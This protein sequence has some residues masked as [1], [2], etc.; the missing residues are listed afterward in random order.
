MA[1]SGWIVAMTR[2]HRENWAVE[3]LCRQNYE[4]Y[5]PRIGR[6][7]RGF[8]GVRYLI[9]EPLFRGYVFIA[10]T[11]N[12]HPIASTFGIIS[13][14]LQGERPAIMP[15]GEV[16]KLR[17]LEDDQGF[18]HLPRLLPGFKTD[19]MVRVLDG[20]YQG[21]IG[22]WQGSSPK[23]RERILLDFM[24]QK[25]KVLIDSRLIEAV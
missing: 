8:R 22:L 3:N 9:P 4:V 16:Q 14:I 18:I 6:E 12:W 11:S 17:H 1:I 20:P 2:S 24:G 23:Q 15:D 5:L 13:L 25:T 19:Q 10:N 21:H 7:R